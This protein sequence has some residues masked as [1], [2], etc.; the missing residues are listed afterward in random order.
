M[1]KEGSE[2]RLWD[3]RAP[4]VIAGPEILMV[5]PGGRSPG[6]VFR[7]QEFSFFPGGVGPGWENLLFSF[8]PGG[9][10]WDRSRAIPVND[11]ISTQKPRTGQKWRGG[12]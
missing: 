5:S 4:G 2:P 11:W 10:G 9:G 12:F 6:V 8:S 1:V 7:H 3:K